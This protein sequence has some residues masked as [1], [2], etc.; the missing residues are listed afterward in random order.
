[1]ATRLSRSEQVERNRERVIAAA[2]E[3]FTESGYTKATLEA[4]AERAGFSKGVVYSQFDSKADL[5]LVL[6][7]RRIAERAE[8]NRRRTAGLDPA[9]AIASFVEVAERDAAADPSWQ[10]VLVE[11]RAHAAR[12]PSVN[13]RYAQLHA[14]TV[15]D[16]G[17]LLTGLYAAAGAQP[18]AAPRVLAEFVLAVGTGITLERA[19]ST[20][21]LPTR[22]LHALVARALGF[23]ED[24]P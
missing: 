19:A 15:D 16:L 6:L 20:S 10:R 4:I 5:F 14:R 13:E 1:M 2:R 24:T 21:A 3:V 12:E 23:P 9:A 8:E 18:V 22:D 11:F 7:E 17:A